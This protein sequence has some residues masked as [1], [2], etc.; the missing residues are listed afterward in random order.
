MRTDLVDYLDRI[1][2]AASEHRGPLLSLL[3]IL[4]IWI[5]YKVL[6]NGLRRT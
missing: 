6:T 2:G 1:L 5:G 4:V 3:T